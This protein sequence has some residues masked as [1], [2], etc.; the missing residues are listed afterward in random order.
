MQNLH[1]DKTEI[2]WKIADVTHLSAMFEPQSF[3]V[4]FDKGVADSLLFRN[5]A[6]RGAKQLLNQV[7]TEIVRVLAPGGH[8]I[9]V[10]PRQK[11]PNAKTAQQLRTRWR[12]PDAPE[13]A[14]VIF[15]SISRIGPLECSPQADPSAVNADARIVKRDRP[16]YF[17]CCTK[18][19]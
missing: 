15:H 13:E 1:K 16:V 11:L 9:V 6:R 7:H 5:S 18:E 19:P 14:P 4:V 3:D 2:L 17:Y 8:Y 12:R 10:S